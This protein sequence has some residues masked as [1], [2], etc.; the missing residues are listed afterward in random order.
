MPNPFI[1]M[2]NELH[3]NHSIFK[4]IFID[5]SH[6]H[7]LILTHQKH[8]QFALEVAHSDRRLAAN[9]AYSQVLF[10]ELLI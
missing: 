6:L 7:L 3:I 2:R 8:S 1:R 9:F 10:V 5:T 4:L